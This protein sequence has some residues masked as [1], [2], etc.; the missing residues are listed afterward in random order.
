MGSILRNLSTIYKFERIE[1]PLL[2]GSFEFRDPESLPSSSYL[3]IQTPGDPIQG[4]APTVPGGPSGSSAAS[5][6]S[7]P[8][9]QPPPFGPAGQGS[10]SQGGK[11]TTVVSDFSLKPICD[12][13]IVNWSW[14]FFRWWCYVVNCHPPPPM[15][16][17]L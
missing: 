12:Q 3:V 6:L 2:T 4:G 8:S 16:C 9:G 11:G 10:V 14:L 17:E 1:K 15:L 5:Q 7:S 13:E